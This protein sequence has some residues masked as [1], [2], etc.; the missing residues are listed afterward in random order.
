MISLYHEL[1]TLGIFMY[2]IYNLNQVSFLHPHL[3]HS[4]A[5]LPLVFSFFLITS[6]PA[7][8]L[9]HVNPAPEAPADGLW[10]T[11]LHLCLGV[12]TWAYLWWPLGAVLAGLSIVVVVGHA[13]DASGRWGERRGVGV[14]GTAGTAHACDVL[15]GIRACS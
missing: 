7:I 11:L 1:F 13:I 6:C 3:M 2:H 8:S 14:F 5:S 10:C 12:G 9:V 4:V 15:S